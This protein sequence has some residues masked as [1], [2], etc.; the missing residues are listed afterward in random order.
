MSV[1]PADLPTGTVTFLLTDIEGS[2]EL[3]RRLGERWPAVVG[4]HKR[5]L[6]EA[7]DEAGGHEV[8]ARGEEVFFAFRRAQDAVGAA[9]AAQR[10]LAS[11]SWPKGAGVRV[12]MGLHTGKPAL[13]DDGGYL[14][15]DVH[16]TARIC[17]AGH[18]GQVLV[19]EA[20]RAL[21]L[22]AGVRFVDLGEYQFRGF[23]REERVYQLAADGLA[24]Q[25]PSLRSASAAPFAGQ[26]RSL[27]KSAQ[28]LVSRRRPKLP[29]VL[30]RRPSTARRLADL[31][32]QVRS[33]QGRRPEAERSALLELAR[34]L[35]V[36]SRTVD[37]A[38]RRL[39][40][41]DRRAFERRLTET[42]ELAVISHYARTRTD[43]LAR[44]GALLD[45]LASACEV[46]DE[47]INEFERRA[48]SAET[49][50][51][52]LRAE[53]DSLDER[54]QGAL[55]RVASEVGDAAERLHRT[56][57]RGIYRQG[58][59][60]AVPYHDSQGAKRARRF[61]D[62]DEARS[63]RRQ[64]QLIESVQIAEDERARERRREQGSLDHASEGDV[65]GGY[66]GDS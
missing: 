66:P 53:V 35:V 27:A 11:H 48:K 39:A 1:A 44:Q 56:V 55:D 34:S 8:D 43:T 54:L 15:L 25:F 41:V 21:A 58:D 57:H 62:L 19:S 32:W 45:E 3:A 46:L 64:Q 28:G 42:R 29:A 23:A 65:F 10:S 5:L 14:G 7:V 20:T 13:G 26:E 63:F 30:R 4:E 2:T 50:T 38:D 61:D 17:A 33:E 40:R 52:S 36:L 12:R 16:R 47:R 22:D 60:W 9:V 49:D 18:G 6:R 51:G 37:V 59:L 31:S 24:E